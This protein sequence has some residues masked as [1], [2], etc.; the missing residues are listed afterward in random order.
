VPPY[1]DA[2]SSY[3]RGLVPEGQPVLVPAG[4]SLGL[5]N[6]G[7]RQAAENFGMLPSAGDCSVAFAKWVCAQAFL[8]CSTNLLAKP[9]ISMPQNQPAVF[10]IPMAFPQ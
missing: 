7:V 8:P 9:Y 2:P 3:C 1:E 6:A 4:M 5:L 10:S